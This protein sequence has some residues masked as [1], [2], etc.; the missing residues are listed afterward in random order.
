M[1]L[2]FEKI[3]ELYGFNINEKRRESTLNCIDDCLSLL[4]RCASGKCKY[5]SIKT[6]VSS[7][8][9]IILCCERLKELLEQDKFVDDSEVNQQ[10]VNEINWLIK[11][12]G[13]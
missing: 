12:K 6:V 13:L 11:E 1:K 2:D 8:S 9:D 7:I 10:I 5:N 4:Q 3:S